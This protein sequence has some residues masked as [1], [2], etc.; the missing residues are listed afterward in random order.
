MGIPC[1]AIFS[2]YR[3]LVALFL[4][5]DALFLG[6][7]ANT[8]S[9]SPGEAKLFFY[10]EGAL[11]KTL[12]FSADLFG[13]TNFAL[14]APFIAL[15]IFNTLMIY[16]AARIGLSRFDSFLAMVL[17]ALLPGVN[18]SALLVNG[19]SIA[20][21]AAL[22]FILLYQKSTILAFSFLFE[23]SMMNGI[24]LAIWLG[25]LIYEIKE[26]QFVLSAAAAFFFAVSIGIWG[27]DFGH[28]PR[29]YFLDIFGLYGAIFSPLIFAYFI[30]ALYWFLFRAKEKIPL[31]WFISAVP[32]LFSMLLSLRQNL[33]IEEF[34][35]YAAVSTPLMVRSFMN[36]WRVRLPQ[37]RRSQKTIAAVLF[38]SLFLTLLVIFFH[39][40]LYM[41]LSDSN[42]HFA[43]N[44]HFADE[45]AGRLQKLGIDRVKCDSE[46]LAIR[47]RYYGIEK[48]GENRLYT[49]HAEGAEPLNFKV[50]GRTAAT[51]YLI[52]RHSDFLLNLKERRENNETTIIQ[53]PL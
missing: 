40:P 8:L 49:T 2:N 18:S 32:F 9:I 21:S 53:E 23:A 27:F 36:S 29:G 6:F 20:I 43:Y 5:L 45:L 41:I 24:F 50:L 1:L 42:R 44:F 11:G 34:A 51:F 37:F 13:R 15:H 4:V 35:P 17:F 39:K 33:A 31:L 46:R 48:G 3:A 7:Y 26:R 38:G 28:R 22:I 12:R 25:V 47:L 14:R 10:D 19:A 30:Y 52:G 16:L